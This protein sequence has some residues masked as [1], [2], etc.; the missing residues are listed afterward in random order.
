[1]QG[2]GPRETGETMTDRQKWIEALSVAIRDQWM[3]PRADRGAA[4][5]A[6]D[7]AAEWAKRLVMARDLEWCT[8]TEA[9][10]WTPPPWA[11]ALDAMKEKP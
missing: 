1:M 5:I 10:V 3:R 7:L 11:A 6:A 4:E 8:D 2:I 9:G